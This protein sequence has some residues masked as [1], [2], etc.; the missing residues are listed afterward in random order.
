M[1]FGQSNE[2]YIR[3]PVVVY[4]LLKSVTGY[5][6]ELD[7]GKAGIF[8]PGHG[9]G[10]PSSDVGQNMRRSM[11]F[12]FGAGPKDWFPAVLLSC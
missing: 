6:V 7:C 11:P 8:S 12:F 1:C 10:P 2:G 4:S 3:V 9:Y 5:V